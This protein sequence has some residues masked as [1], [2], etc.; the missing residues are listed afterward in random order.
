MKD[1]NGF[2]SFLDRLL[3]VCFVVGLCLLVFSG[4]AFYLRYKLPGS[5]WL[6]HAFDAADTQLQQW[7]LEREAMAP[8]QTL[9]S[10]IASGKVITW[11]RN[12]TS[13]GYIVLT[14][15]LSSGGTIYLLGMDGQPVYH[16]TVPLKIS[17]DSSATL[18]IAKVHLMPDGSL[19]V[20]FWYSGHTPYGSN[21]VKVDKDSN[22]VWTYHTNAHHDLYVDQENNDIYSLTHEVVQNS[23]AGL[24]NL[25]S[26]ML[27][28]SITLLSSNGQ[29][30]RHISI[31]NAFS[32]TPYASYLY[33]F[34][35][36]EWD[37]FH[38]NSVMKLE[39]EMAKH[40]PMF[41]AGQILVSIRNLDLLAVIDPISE[42]V[43]WACRGPWKGQHAAQFL[44]N[45]HILLLDNN[46][47]QTQGKNISR[48]IEFDPATLGIS[49]SYA[50]ITPEDMFYT[51]TY[52]QIQR[53]PN[54]NTL[55]ISSNEHKMLEVTSDG[56]VV[57]KI[58][59][60]AISLP[61]AD[62]RKLG[63][64][65]PIITSRRYSPDE[66]PFLKSSIIDN[67]DTKADHA[68]R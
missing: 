55:I 15:D 6:N 5:Q 22:V 47:Y 1:S 19:I 23:V 37:H 27:A 57:W 3:P 56:T 14:T 68:I 53:L 54:G 4:G 39:P 2:P 58:L 18:D 30:L 29:E 17:D 21:I 62:K 38:T 40:F 51:P 24:E 31:L 9:E 28:D 11:D 35:E 45:G 52:G 13:N 61:D 60:P 66:L 65:D 26:P 44:P 46:G 34:D 7:K 42:K 33:H 64:S 32:G 36:N 41:S 50:N 59:F 25:P 63:F 48:A 20:L 10:T 67:N 16:W 8:Q 12:R 43:V 49:W